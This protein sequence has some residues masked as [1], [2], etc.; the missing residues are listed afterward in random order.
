MSSLADDLSSRSDDQLLDL[1]RRR[2][3]LATPPPGGTEVLA[4][5]A[6][7]PQSLQVIGD[8]LDVLSVA[9]LEVLIGASEPM[10]TDDV[11]A[12]L[13]ERA[14]EENVRERLDDLQALALVW[15]SGDGLTT[16]PAAVAALPS[17]GLVYTAPLTTRSLA[18]ISAQL[19]A[20][21][22]GQHDLLQTLSEG[23]SV[24]RTRDAA[25][26]ADPQR[27]V[28][29][30][31]AAG[32][33]VRIDDQTVQL[34]PVVG[35]LLRDETPA[36][37]LSLDEP[38][39]DTATSRFTAKDIDAAGGGEAL[40]LLRHTAA[41]LDALGAAPAALLRS[42][43][44]GIRELRK[45]S[46]ATGLTDRRTALIIELLGSARLID[47]G[48]ADPPP[49]GDTG[50]PVWAPTPA[51]DSWRH[52][53]PEK[54][55]QTLVSAWLTMP[56]LSW[57]IGQ[58]APESGPIGALS[59][60]AIYQ[61][62]AAERAMILGA[63]AAAAPGR[64][65]DR[66]ALQHALAWRHPRRARRFTPS[67][68]AENLGEAQDLGLIAHDSLT[69]VGRA[70]VADP[71]D[72]AAIESAMAAALPAPIDHFLIQ[73]DL[74]IT[75]PGPLNSEL[76]E[77][78]SLVADLE[79]AGAATVFRVSESTVRRALDAG[80]S[81]TD[82]LT[83]F[84]NHSRTPVPQS[85]TYLVED[86]GRRHGQLRAGIASS[87]LRCDDPTTL[88]A[89]M[90][91]PAAEALSLRLLAPTVAISGAELGEVLEELRNAGFAPAA[92]DSSG[93][94]VEIRYRGSRV[95]ARRVVRDRGGVPRPRVPNPEQLELVLSH[96]RSQDSAHRAG[97]V[98]EARVGGGE[99]ATLL[100]T[101]AVNAGRPVR[102]GYVDAQGTA[103]RH[104]LAPRA[105]SA[106]M[107][108]GDEIDSPDEI[109][110]RL[111]RITS[112]ELLTLTDSNSNSD[113]RVTARETT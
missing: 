85:L 90:S 28:P 71:D 75:A 93:A 43:G 41:V 26:H 27:P 82:L 5:R 55:W 18:D 106:G 86:V 69:S 46:K 4:R 63:M 17:G 67:V 79:S 53:S 9:V 12:A 45:I 104:V 87:F 29:Q 44:L 49:A 42:G 65:V 64:T 89:V 39:I 7:S 95:P 35:A 112:V 62:A 19:Q 30:L 8:Q 77:E 83:L 68:I 47:H 91:S 2:P 60:E 73:A 80:R 103:S 22:P 92:E 20:L 15:A 100:L 38:R 61:F 59:G 14:T 25:P 72:H 110:L 101:K 31:L 3:D 76:A 98:G 37:P 48:F 81:A 111:H 113:S 23:S 78:V 84:I 11:A 99:A 57:L 88:A 36:E 54:R 16:T 52:L 97:P 109:R 51:A 33:L 58:K 10:S 66:T 94:L 6:T 107:V 105:I 1:L 32:L 50:E 40:E 13:R 34:P 102:I 24:G 74:T 21:P 96:I 108:I 56:R 70:V